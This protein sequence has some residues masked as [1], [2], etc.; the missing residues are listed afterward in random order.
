MHAWSI[1]TNTSFSNIVFVIL[2]LKVKILYVNKQNN[3]HVGNLK[4][5]KVCRINYFSLQKR[6]YLTFHILWSIKKN[7]ELLFSVRYKRRT[8]TTY[9]QYK[10]KSKRN[11]LKERNLRSKNITKKK[12]KNWSFFFSLR[13]KLFAAEKVPD[14]C[15]VR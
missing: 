15:L 11:Q 10:I 4:F 2:N 7:H 8:H 1:W 14:R 6:E 9:S 12:S 13:W 3:M 5:F